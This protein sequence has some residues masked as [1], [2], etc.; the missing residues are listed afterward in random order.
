MQPTCQTDPR[1]DAV[2]GATGRNGLD[3]VEVGGDDAPAT[4]YVHF[5]GKLPPELA[6]NRPGIERF[7]RIAGGERITGLRILDADPQAQSDPT[8]DDVLVLTLDRSGD[9]SPYTLSLAGVQGI[10]PRYAS[11]GF[12]FGLCCPSDLDCQAV[13]ACDGPTADEPQINYLAKDYE[14]FRELILDR[15]ALLMP[16]WTERHVPDLGITLVEIL[17]YAGD[18]LSYYQDAVATEAYLGTARQRISVRRHARLVDYT[19][20]EGC[21]ART[22]LHFDVAG[23][24]ALPTDRIAFA[25]GCNQSRV[26][27]PHVLAIG[28]LDKLPASSYEFYEP[29]LA[30]APQ[31]LQLRE[32]HNA[33]PFYSWG[34]RECCLPTGATCA[35]LLDAW[36]PPATPN[37]APTRALAIQVG[38]VLVFEEVVGART[39]VAA[40]A[41]PGHRWAVRITSVVVDTDSLYPVTIGTGDAARSLPTPIVEIGW[42]VADALPFSLCL[43]AIGLAPGC[44]YLTDISVAR[45]NVIL[46]D[47]GRRQDDE[48]LPPVPGSTSAACCECECE[49]EPGDVRVQAGRYR[50]ALAQAPV[51]HGVALA[52]AAVPASQGLVQDPRAA[53]PALSLQD[54]GGATWG[55][56][57]DLLASGPDDRDVVVETDNLGIAHLRF[58]DGELGRQP[59]IGSTFAASYRTGGGVAG[60]VGAEAISRL[61]LKKNY[62]I[63]GDSISVRNP[64]PAVGGVDPEPIA[65]ARLFAPG[66]FSHQIERAITAADYAELA[67]RNPA[68]Q[69]AAAALAWTG[70]WY[71]ADV[72]VDPLGTEAADPALLAAIACD[73]HRYR[74]IGHDLRVQ[75]AVYVPLKLRL[76]VCALPGYDRGHVKAALLER[77]G[78]GPAAGGRPAGFFNA[79]QLTLGESVRLGWIVAAGQ[80][81][82][83]VECVR[84]TAF[85]RLFAASNHEIDN[86]VL[87][88]APCEIAQLD[89]DPDHPE[90]GQLHIDVRGGRQETRMN[91]SINPGAAR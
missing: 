54:S 66:A 35:T 91:L 64:L 49:G 59:D 1:R 31:T 15:L 88:L 68:L 22:W 73:L 30:Q 86:G 72:A 51:V 69:G 5:L 40:D 36:V 12:T 18:Q 70:S 56:R 80:A 85:H 25:T 89:N 29:L 76:E 3:Y 82:A 21:N 43:S 53:V 2:R 87:P 50:P 63:D 34:R 79:D 11:A 17:A 32:A 8:R 26:D 44:V 42:S 83:G 7:L 10:D 13:R 37:D 84:V 9:F 62:A 48:P 60:N 23:S 45:G 19:L 16:G 65:A 41:D 71:E 47:H 46:I 57:P 24:I 27:A 74:R 52:D 39:G 90:R 14:S 75:P 78:T 33:I 4:L 77:F 38:D 67:E 81:V 55:V 6:V 20:H 28:D 58:G 61:V